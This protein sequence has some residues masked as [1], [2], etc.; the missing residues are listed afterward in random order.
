[1]HVPMAILQLLTCL[2]A[3]ILSTA[4]GSSPPSIPHQIH[5]LR[6]QTGAAGE[7]VVGVSCL[8]WRLGVE[9]NNII[10]WKQVPEKCAGYLG[11]YM[12]GHQYR[13]DSKV[14][15]DEAFL[16][17]KSLRLAQDGKNI[18]VFDIDETSLSNLPYYAKHGFGV[19]LYNATA[20][21]EWVLTG[22][23]LAL[24]ESLKL[25]KKLLS[26]GIKVAFLTGRPEDQRTVTATNLKNAGF[27]TW[28]KLILKDL[29]IYKGKT[30]VFFKSNERAKLE[31]K[32]YR[33]IG[34][35]GDQWSDLLGIPT[36][37]RTFKLPDPMK[38]P[39]T[40]LELSHDS[41]LNIPR[42][43]H[44]LRPKTTGATF[45]DKVEGLSCLSWRLA[46]ETNNIIGWKTVP[47]ECEGYVGNY[48][49]GGQYR[50]DS[51]VV[52]NQA[53]LY[54][55]SLNL[56]G[57]GK[58]V[59]VFDIDETSLSNLPYYADNGFGV[60]P[61]NASQFNE[62]VLKGVAP[63]LPE[64][65]ELYHKLLALG[66]KVVFLTGRGEDQITVTSNNLKNTGY[67]TWEKLILKIVGNIGD[68]WSDL[69]GSSTGNRT[70]KLPDPLYYIA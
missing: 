15:T 43:I 32:G 19:E 68:Q 26:L 12:L 7:S 55:K 33:I 10:N 52:T 59:W 56:S 25:Y 63:P 6:P 31:K 14:I 29:S 40:I 45:V 58:D 11:H 1:M 23:A 5:L 21:N 22:K 53:F 66:I 30:A 24:P 27:K 13:E 69:L 37:N 49:L 64:S 61:Y 2:I 70:F 50:E 28:E 46:V 48:V 35:I 42:Q 44:L 60:E 54:A 20:F 8:S 17:A 39:Q 67:H 36:G 18:W 3:A 9:T 47:Q 65:L 62:W 41:L 57:D 38:I 34:N 51:R 4:Q 16:Y